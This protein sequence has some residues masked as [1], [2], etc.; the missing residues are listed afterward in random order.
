MT[1]NSLRFAKR[2]ESIAPR[3]CCPCF[4]HLFGS[5]AGE[6]RATKR[7]RDLFSASHRRHDPNSVVAHSS[8]FWVLA[9]TG[10]H[11]KAIESGRKAVVLDP[12][13]FDTRFNLGILLISQRRYA[14]GLALQ[15]NERRSLRPDDPRPRQQIQQAPGGS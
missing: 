9:Q 3:F 12:T 4:A 14:E 2:F 10:Q 5:T 7:G 6:G 13:S 15:M 8:L 11:E 1:P